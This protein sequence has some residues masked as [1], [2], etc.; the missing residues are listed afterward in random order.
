MT[1]HTSAICKPKSFC[2]HGSFVPVQWGFRP[3]G[4]S[5]QSRFAT[6]RVAEPWRRQLPKQVA[7][8]PEISC[9]Y[10]QSWVV[11]SSVV[12]MRG[13]Q[14]GKKITQLIHAGGHGF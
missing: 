14:G 5:K 8:E 9:A 7:S 6:N 10:M 2:G 13:G 3:L 4:C 1:Y 11:D 12:L